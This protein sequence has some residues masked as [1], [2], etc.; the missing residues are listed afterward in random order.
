MLGAEIT[1]KIAQWRESASNVQSPDPCVT[2]M[3]VLCE[4]MW[5][6]I[7]ACTI[8]HICYPSAEKRQHPYTL[9][10]FPKALHS[11]SYVGVGSQGCDS[12]WSRCSWN[13][14]LRASWAFAHPSKSKDVVVAQALVC[15]T[16]IHTERI[17]EDLRLFRGVKAQITKWFDF[18]KKEKGKK[19][20]WVFMSDTQPFRAP[21]SQYSDSC[22]I[23]GITE[24]W[25]SWTVLSDV[26]LR[27]FYFMWGFSMT[28]I[29]NALWRV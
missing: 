12:P 24:R 19:E 5:N 16:R 9:S 15:L 26:I 2:Y 13:P 22:C 8:L 25:F 11:L 4:L 3:C 21:N 14:L 23:E 28:F 29:E 10:F 18:C 7:L 6:H 1:I 27:T 20:K 17:H